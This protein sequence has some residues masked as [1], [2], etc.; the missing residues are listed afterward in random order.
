[1]L[2]L[3][4][5]G[6]VRKNGSSWQAVFNFRD[7]DTGKRTQRTFPTGIACSASDNRGRKGALA[8]KEEIRQEL[9]LK[10][11]VS[12]RGGSDDLVEAI[13]ELIDYR[14]KT[15]AITFQTREGYRY[16]LKH[17][18]RGFAGVA[19]GDVTSRGIQDWISASIDAGH[20]PN[21]MTKA[22]KVLDMFYRAEMAHEGGRV[23]RNPCD[24]VKMPRQRDPKPN[25]LTR[26]NLERF[27][28]MLSVMPDGPF[29]RAAMLA[30]NCGMRVGECS[31]LKWSLV[32][33]ENRTVNIYHSLAKSE[34]GLALKDNKGHERR[35]APMNLVLFC[36]LRELR[37]STIDALR[38]FGVKDPE[39][40]IE[41]C[42]VVSGT[43]E[44]V[45]PQ[46]ISKKY[47]VVSEANGLFGVSGEL[48]TF[49]GLRH[50][51]AT[52]WI[53]GGGDVKS[54]SDVLGHKDA[55]MT[56]NV[57]AGCDELARRQGMA[58]TAPALNRGY[59]VKSFGDAAEEYY[60]GC[61]DLYTMRIP[62]KVWLRVAQVASE[63]SASVEDVAA[64]LL[65]TVLDS[66]K[67]K[68]RGEVLEMAAG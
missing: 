28:Q 51:F 22:Y 62:A 49:H 17:I 61:D 68:K 9:I 56:L 1:M 24:G 46:L 20:S 63:R 64:G 44:H 19:V 57:Y 10:D 38:D 39:K 59:D 31:A 7:D 12:R 8:R 16:S 34:R 54:L 29:R 35:Q 4:G 6:S 60:D 21:T 45:S 25:P 36:Y 23:M 11:A 33:F 5:E 58:L 48:T 2:R 55:S 32:D 30:L 13:G 15:N 41:D 52:T 67:A 40:F 42:F 3:T 65:E 43:T 18:A 47:S 66:L 37:A 50:T 53:A 27:N 14:Y 26:A